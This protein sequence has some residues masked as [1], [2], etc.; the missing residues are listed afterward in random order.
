[1]LK[2]R[3]SD[4]QN[5]NEQR[6]SRPDRSSKNQRRK[7]TKLITIKCALRGRIRYGADP[8]SR[9]R[10]INQLEKRVEAYSKR[11]VNASLAFSG[12][13]KGI[14]KSVDPSQDTFS[15]E[16]PS[17]IA[18]VDVPTD[19]FSQTF[20]RQ[21]LLG[22]VG[23][24]QPIQMI[25]E[26]HETHPHLLLAGNR[27]LGVGGIAACRVAANRNIYS[28]GAIQYL[29]NLKNAL[30]EE[31]GDR[32]KVAS[33]RLGLHDNEARVVRYR[34]NGW[35]V[36]PR[37]GCC[38][39][40]PRAAEEAVSMHRRMLG[41]NEQTRI[42]D[43]WMRNDVAAL[44]HAPLAQTTFQRCFATMYSSTRCT[45]TQIRSSSTSYQSAK[46]G[47]TSSEWLRRSRYAALRQTLRYCT[48]FYG[49]LGL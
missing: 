19:L 34:I 6:R 45:K 10:I 46:S 31:L 4:D 13:V 7:V 49:T 25:K 18:D 23:T 24:T 33:R 17:W 47:P 30:R 21:L 15:D 44:R 35:T 3:R 5:N 16:D 11:I 2:R 48:E 14:F 28:A 41:L 38:F 22:T 27:H 43:D 1:M 32:I 36:P 39:P 26:Y 40:Q 42:N 12:I 8:T 37:F 20:F 29:T 9:F